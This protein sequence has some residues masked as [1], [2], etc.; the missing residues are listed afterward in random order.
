MRVKTCKARIS[1]K[2]KK[3][4]G[5]KFST[6]KKNRKH[7]SEQCRKRNSEILLREKQ[8]KV[9][10]VK[11]VEENKEKYS[12]TVLGRIKKLVNEISDIESEVVYYK[13]LSKPKVKKGMDYNQ[14]FQIEELLK[15]YNY[16]MQQFKMNEKYYEEMKIKKV[17]Q[18]VRILRS[19]HHNAKEKKQVEKI[20]LSVQTELHD[21][22]PETNLVERFDS[23]ASDMLPK[24]KPDFYEALQQANDK[25]DNSDFI[26]Y[27]SKRR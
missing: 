3:K 19:E 9:Q 21:M 18:V 15:D 5:N 12:V 8:I 14:K 13:T 26:K 16:K 27:F 22:F 7:C 4:C 1:S 20:V 25:L 23:L 17:G 6:K 11:Q 24:K 10:R 2:N